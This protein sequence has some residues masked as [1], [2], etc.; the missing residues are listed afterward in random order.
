MQKDPILERLRKL[1]AHEKSA[2]SI[3]SIKEAE[4]FASKIQE[5]LTEHK[6]GMDEVEFAERE[7]QEPIGF[8]EDVDPSEV[9]FHGRRASVQWQLR[10]GRTIAMC[11]TCKLVKCEGNKVCFAGRDSDRLACKTL[12]LYFLELAKEMGEK[13]ALGHIEEQK[14]L[15]ILAKNL[16][17]D[18]LPSNGFSSE[19]NPREFSAWMRDYRKSWY[20]GFAHAVCTR[21]YDKYE[22]ATKGKEK[23][24]AMIHINRD[25]EAIQKW[26][27]DRT[28]KSNAGGGRFSNNSGYERGK[29]RGGVV[30]LTSNRV[31]SSNRPAVALL[32]S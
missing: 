21:L 8:G 26:V 30:N 22:A 2:R 32:S 23:T 9:G 5:L 15:F 24:T 1:V 25:V 17:L 14:A 16:R 18:T 28:V 31:A 10:L 3:G 7:E 13:D 11:N 19:Y 4:A 20:S 27:T 6:L 29:R 12:F